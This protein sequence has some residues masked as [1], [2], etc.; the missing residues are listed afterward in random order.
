MKYTINFRMIFAAILFLLFVSIS[1]KKENR[2]QKKAYQAN[3][4]TLYR[5]SPVTPSNI[6]INGTSYVT[7]A[8]FPGKGT[9]T[10]TDMTSCNIYFN[11][12]AYSTSPGGNPV[13]SE[14]APV[15][16]IIGYPVTGA[17][18]PLI[19]PG[20]FNTLQSL[21]TDLSLPA[22]KNGKVISTVIYDNTGNAVYLSAIS[23]SNTT[24]PVSPTRV[25][26]NGKAVIAG[27][28]G[29]FSTAEGNVDFNGYFNPSN[30]NDAAFNVTGT[31]E[32]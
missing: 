27:G 11:Q 3:T 28:H 6:T 8:N 24:S 25:D 5:V 10:A 26:F 22:S 21:I 32:Y 14:P 17:P 18:L 15:T 13:G 29:K 2:K 16:E 31:I 19:Q 30:P 12:I 9:G 1:C 7:T 20:D 23:G 4:V